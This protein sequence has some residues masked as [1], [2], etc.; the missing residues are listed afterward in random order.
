MNLSKTLLLVK[1]TKK[2]K[3]IVKKIKLSMMSFK[4]ASL[5]LKP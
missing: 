2:Y 4:N 1:L 5:L 3:F